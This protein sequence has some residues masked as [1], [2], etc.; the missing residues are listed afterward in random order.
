MNANV[1]A[2]R[3]ATG[4]IAKQNIAIAIVMYF[5]DQNRRFFGHGE[6]DQIMLL[7]NDGAVTNVKKTFTSVI[8]IMQRKAK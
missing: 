8:Q 1:E 4:N 3:S 6:G 7:S 5:T 2:Y